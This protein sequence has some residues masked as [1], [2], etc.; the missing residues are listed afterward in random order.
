MYDAWAIYSKEARPYLIGN[1]VRGFTSELLSFTPLESVEESRKK[2]ISYA[3][4]RLLSHRFRISPG[5]I[6]TQERLDLIMAQLG[7]DLN[8]TDSDYISGDARALGNYIGQTLIAY[9]NQDGARE[10][11]DY[12]NAFYQPINFPLNPNLTNDF[13]TTNPN[14]WQPLSLNG[15]VDQSGNLIE[16]DV[17]DFLSPEWGAVNGFALTDNEKTIYNRG[18]NTYSVFN[19]PDAPPYLNEN[20]TRSSKSYKWGF[21][22]VSVWQ[23]HLDTSDN[24]FWDISPK[25]I[26]NINFNSLPTNYEEY[27]DFYKFF[28]GGD[29]SQGRDINPITQ[30]PYEEQ[31]VPRGDYARV[32]AEFWADGPDSET[33]PGHWFTILNYVN[34]NPF[35]EKRFKGEGATLSP[36]EWDVKSYF[37][38]GGAM[39][40]AAISAWSIKGW[41]DYIRPISAIRYMASRGQSSDNTA[42][43]YNM[44]GIELIPNY[45]ELVSENDPLSGINGEH[46]NKIKLRTL[47]LARASRNQF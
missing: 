15:F 23:S 10:Q 7:Y 33:P 9:G 11:S 29:I 24:V 13:L 25:T 6:E 40:D 47:F 3:A 46:I 1:T 34:D 14:R 2:A 42:P 16:G 36:L 28:E 39:H 27:P 26:G 43:N 44:E 18:G 41:Y 30:Q 4:Y 38:L 35:L 45:I 20:D 21:S 31:V 22:M 37:I 19:D 12:N 17:I 5:V 8:F 32:L